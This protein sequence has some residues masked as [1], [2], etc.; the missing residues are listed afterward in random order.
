MAPDDL[1]KHLDSHPFKPKRMRMKGTYIL[2][3]W[4]RIHGT[5]NCQGDR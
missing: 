1:K 5:L 3:S 2:F 4:P